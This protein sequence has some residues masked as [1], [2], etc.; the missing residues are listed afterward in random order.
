MAI[1]GIKVEPEHRDFLDTHFG[2]SP[3]WSD[4]HKKL[5]D[6]TFVNAVS[7]DTR[8]D[9]KLKA[10]AQ[11]LNMRDQSKGRSLKVP[12]DTSG[13]YKV[14]FHQEANRFSCTCPDWTYKRS[15]GGGDCKH[16]ERLKAAKKESL[17]KT[18]SVISPADVLFRVG[19][20]VNREHND[21]AQAKKLKAEN[22]AYA[23]AYPQQPFLSQWMKRAESQELVNKMTKAARRLLAP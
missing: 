1:D 23:Q 18:A 7:A 5:K 13:S 19:R 21:K 20:V 3:Q 8:S 16:I 4:F 11:A 9:D 22:S 15:V 12:S 14:K 2:V 10:F 6:R 17:M